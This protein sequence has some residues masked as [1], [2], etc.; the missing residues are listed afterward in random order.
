MKPAIQILRLGLAALLLTT[1][2]PSLLA[3]PPHTG[4]RGQA[5]IYYPG[6]FVE[7]EPGVW[8][9][10]GGFALPVPTSFS[11]LSAH[12]GHQVGHFTTDAGGG[13]EV[14]LPPGKYVVV[15]D[16]L[17]MAFGCSVPTGSF[18]LTVRPKQFADAVIWYFLAEPCSIT[19]PPLP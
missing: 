16:T 1:S 4:I 15:P 12:S 2:P 10:H 5:V 8:L 18:E 7:V 9:G 14:S 11:V 17:I 13:F 3:A 19:L 6:S